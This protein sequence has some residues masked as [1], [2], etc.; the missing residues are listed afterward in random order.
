M[1]GNNIMKFMKESSLHVSN[2][3]RALR[4]AKLDILVDFICS[5]QL[6]ITVITCKVAFPSNLQIIENYVKSVD[7]INAMG[8]NIPHLPQSKSYLKITGILYYSYDDPSKCLS[9]NNIEEIIKQNQIFDNIV[10]TSKL[11][12]IKVLP[13]SD[14]SIIWVDIWNVQSRSKTKGLINCCF[15]IGNYIATIRDANMNLGVPQCKNC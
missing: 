8:V 5:D 1:N 11:H 14:M 10:L 15:N 4:N 2:I 12:V 13:K 7:Y 9:S 3:N 6:G